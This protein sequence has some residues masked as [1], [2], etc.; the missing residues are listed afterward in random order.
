MTSFPQHQCTIWWHK[1]VLHWKF[2]AVDSA[3]FCRH[4]LPNRIVESAF[5]ACCFLWIGKKR[6]RASG[7][8]CNILLGASKSIAP[9]LLYPLFNVLI[10]A[11]KIWVRVQF[12]LPFYP[13]HSCSIKSTHILVLFKSMRR[14]FITNWLL[15]IIHTHTHKVYT[16]SFAVTRSLTNLKK[17]ILSGQSK[18]LYNKIYSECMSTSFRLLCRKWEKGYWENHSFFYVL[19]LGFFSPFFL[20]STNLMMLMSL[21]LILLNAEDTVIY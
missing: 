2:L 6:R 15:H 8:F 21:Y 16:V 9:E 10:F 17:A 5:S 1:F 13:R 14:W 20:V 12:K 11:Y 4:E 7:N 18:M 19:S 3:I